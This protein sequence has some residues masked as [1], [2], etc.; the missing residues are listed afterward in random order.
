MR[1]PP[2]NV[3]G[4]AE[5]AAHDGTAALRG[6]SQLIA[7][8]RNLDARLPREGCGLDA[9][10]RPDQVSIARIAWMDEDRNAGRQELR[11]RSGDG[12]RPAILQAE[13]ERREERR[14]RDIIDL[15]LRDGGLALEAPE[16]RRNLRIGESSLIE[17][18]KRPLRGALS[19]R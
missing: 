19:E 9:C 18:D 14:Q 11:A 7:K 4:V 6:I 16:R 15:G 5:G 8:D 17:L 1:A 10:R 3:G 12:Q 13:R 2:A